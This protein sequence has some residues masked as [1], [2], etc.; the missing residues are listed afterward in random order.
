MQAGVQTAPIPGFSDLRYPDRKDPFLKIARQPPHKD[1]PESVPLPPEG[2]RINHQLTSSGRW[3]GERY[4]KTF[5]PIFE[6]TTYHTKPPI[7]EPIPEHHDSDDESHSWTPSRGSSFS[8][9]REE[10]HALSPVASPRRTLG[11]SRSKSLSSLQEGRLT[12]TQS[13]PRSQSLGTVTERLKSPE[14]TPPSN[15]SALVPVAAGRLRPPRGSSTQPRP[16]TRGQKAALGIGGALLTAA[17]T[18][19]TVEGVIHS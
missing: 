11:L 9:H 16:L 7:M 14:R 13:L 15:N 8:S 18:T 12:S 4:G 10:P 17:G 6:H 1:W 3:V 5:D 19:A 2:G